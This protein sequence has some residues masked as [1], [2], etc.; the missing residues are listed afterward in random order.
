[1]KEAICETCGVVYII[2][3]KLPSNIECLCKEKNFQ[4][5]SK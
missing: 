1:M 5:I 4:L 2:S 3:D